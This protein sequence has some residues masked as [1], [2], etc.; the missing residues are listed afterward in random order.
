MP[1]QYV[2]IGLVV[3]LAIMLAATAVPVGLS[4]LRRRRAMRRLR[5][6]KV[7]QWMEDRDTWKK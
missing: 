1:S 4:E 7:I 6:P 5:K 2:E 3:A